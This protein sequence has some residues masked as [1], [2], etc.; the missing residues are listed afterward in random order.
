[1]LKFPF[2]R[3]F[4]D[5][6][7]FVFHDFKRFLRMSAA[8]V[9]LYAVLFIVMVAIFGI[10][11]VEPR[12]PMNNPSDFHFD[13]AQIVPQL[14]YALVGLVSNI[15]FAVAWHRTVLLNEQRNFLHA[16]RLRWREWRFFFYS[17]LIGLLAMFV[18]S[19]AGGVFLL[20]GVGMLPSFPA[21]KF[22]FNPWA[23]A[24]MAGFLFVF[25]W[26]MAPFMARFSLGLPAIAVEEPRGVFGR[27]WRRGRHNGWR[28]FWG[29]LLVSIPIGIVAGVMS[30]VQTAV[31]FLTLLSGG[32]RIVGLILEWIFFTLSYGA[33]FLSFAVTISFLSLAYKFLTQNE[34][35]PG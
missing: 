2:W 31:S 4:G 26:V 17:L 11:A 7:V 30:G 20:L 13:P 23:F 22:P 12:K 24:I 35:K 14:I 19:I 25:L 5:S 32:W 28:L 21:D 15:V 3:T 6:F 16:F 29:P 1:M 10:A 9:G 27:S 33:H 34:A 18:F 8:W